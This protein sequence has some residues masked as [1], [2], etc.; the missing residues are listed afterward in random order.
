[1]ENELQKPSLTKQDEKIFT[2]AIKVAA[3]KDILTQV[4]VEEQDLEGN[5]FTYYKT[6]KFKAVDILA[7]QI[8]EL[9]LNPETPLKD[10][11]AV[12]EKMAKI[13]EGDTKT[14]NNN[15]NIGVTGSYEEFI[16]KAEQLRK[17]PNGQ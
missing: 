10:K 16:A 3:N 11:I 8:I 12:F 9:A 13:T 17:L 7:D 15:I 4:P 2:K 5:K 6:K 1:M 14:Q